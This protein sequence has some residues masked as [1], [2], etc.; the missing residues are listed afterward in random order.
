M[1]ETLRILHAHRTY[2]HF[3]EGEV[4]PEV[5]VQAIAAAAQ[6]APSWMNGQC[7]S[8]VRVTDDALRARIVA[9]Q[10]RN[11]QIGTAAEYWIFLA[12]V[13][14]MWLCGGSEA[15]LADTETLITATTDAALAAQSAAIAA[16]SLGYATCFTGSIRA[17]AGDLVALLQLPRHTFPLFGLCMGTAA[18]EMAL[19]PRLPQRAVLF[20]NRYEAD[21][22]EDLQAYEQTMTAFGEAREVLPWREKFA[23]FYAQRYAPENEALRERQG[24]KG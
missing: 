9:L 3:R 21:V 23:R 7:Y 11:P 8:M 6:Q 14:R 16:E 22:A 19:Q 4:M 20:E 18:T 24:L 1:N 5:H 12:D 13:Y 17:V 2:R 15:A 10:P